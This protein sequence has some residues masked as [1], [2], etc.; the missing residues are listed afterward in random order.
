MKLSLYGVHISRILAIAAGFAILVVSIL[1]ATTNPR[2]ASQPSFFGPIVPETKVEYYLPYPGILPDSPVYKIKAMRDQIRLWITFDPIQKA[3]LQLLYADKRI[4]AA[5]TLLEGGKP[6]LA[7]STA[8]KAEKYLEKA[9]RTSLGNR[10]MLVVLAKSIAKHKEI[11]K[12]FQP[13]LE[14]ALETNE[15]MAQRVAQALLEN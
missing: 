15:L 12:I 4:N 6:D 2:A 13:P 11:L 1:S 8:T 9:V 7:I 5:K 10:E 14:N 3:K